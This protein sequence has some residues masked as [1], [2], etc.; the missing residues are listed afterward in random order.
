MKLFLVSDSS[1]W[2]FSVNVVRAATAEEAR[3]LV[4]TDPNFDVTLLDPDGAPGILWSYENSPD[5]RPER[6]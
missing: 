4:T 6:D 3:A 2:S 1:Y 5:S